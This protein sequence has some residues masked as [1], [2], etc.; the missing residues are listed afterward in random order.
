[1][2]TEKQ[3]YISNKIRKIKEDGI[4]GKPVSNDQ[5]IAVAYSYEKRRGK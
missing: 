4:R 5:A 1:M 2:A 3:K